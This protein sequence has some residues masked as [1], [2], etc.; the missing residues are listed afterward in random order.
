MR[1]VVRQK[2]T[3][4]SRWVIAL[5]AMLIGA[6]IAL[7]ISMTAT[8]LYEAYARLYVSTTGGAP[9]SNA[10]YQET[11]ASQ[12]IALSLVKLVQSEA[13]TERVVESLQLDMSPGELPAKMEAVVEPETVLIDLKV[14][15]SSP[16]LAREI[17]NANAFE[18]ADFVDELQVRAAP[19]TPKPKVTLV[20]PA[21]TPMAPVSPNIPR[22]V[23]LGAVAGLGVGFAL[24]S[25]RRRMIRTVHSTDELESYVGATALGSAPLVKSA[26]GDPFE[27]IA[28]DPVLMESFREVRT[29]LV[30]LLERRPS[31]VITVTSAGL[32]EGKT[33]TVCGVATALSDSGFRV[34]VI[35]A[36]LRE[37]TLSGRLNMSAEA[38]LADIVNGAA[39]SAD[40][41]RSVRQE[42]VDVL[43][44]GH[45][46]SQ[47]SELLTS[48]AVEK[49]LQQ[50]AESYDYVIVDTPAVLAFSDAT[51]IATQSDGVILAA[52]YAQVDGEDLAAAVARLAR[53]D[54]TVL[55]A[56]LTFAPMPNT[57][58]R[59]LKRSRR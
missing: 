6:L 11:A 18:F 34:L 46:S 59:S 48:R 31:R 23:G 20:K 36:D 12:Q 24:A 57:L 29:N 32:E 35:D 13:V 2:I 39:E 49:L 4:L 8:P 1:K 28:G 10:S 25:L 43:P 15:D 38:G 17:A 19:S 3:D 47:P 42:R 14:T 7:G 44:A 37:A 58:R 22:N 33:A 16:V 21:A 45:S 53:V 50:M 54:V 51:V 9:V 52:R 55:G 30:H 26:S 27:W 40:V 5:G 41:I 56:V